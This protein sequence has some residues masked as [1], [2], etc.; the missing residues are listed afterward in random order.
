MQT[1]YLHANVMQAWAAQSGTP[2]FRAHV[3][4]G[5]FD[6]T[7]GWMSVSSGN[8]VEIETSNSRLKAI[9]NM[10]AHSESQQ[11]SEH[12]Y[13]Q[14][15]NAC[16]YMSE[17]MILSTRG[18]SKEEISDTP[19]FDDADT[20][21]EAS[22]IAHLVWGYKTMCCGS[23]DCC[24]DV[25]DCQSNIAPSYPDCTS[26]N[27]TQWWTWARCDID[28]ASGEYCSDDTRFF[29]RDDDLPPDGVQEN[30][31][32][33][34]LIDYDG[35]VATIDSTFWSKI[36]GAVSYVLG[37]F[38]ME[39]DTSGTSTWDIQG[40]SGCGNDPVND[41]LWFGSAMTVVDALDLGYGMFLGWD[42][43]VDGN[44]GSGTHYSVID[45]YERIYH[46]DNANYDYLFFIGNPNA[47][48]GDAGAEWDFDMMDNHGLDIADYDDNVQRVGIWDYDFY[49]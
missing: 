24:E 22:A 21:Q 29:W 3:Y 6:T 42:G 16:G 26:S 25:E 9:V 48:S 23:W 19:P 41:A 28:T 2:S 38:L 30:D 46:P 27:Y 44:C 43:V 10:S 47:P 49:Q 37:K 35:V 15:V 5:D 31:R 45:G 4:E 33:T 39:Q 8:T 1:N 20:W 34:D 18:F 12:T 32:F 36:G 40:D 17:D 7:D 13:N 11:D 14:E